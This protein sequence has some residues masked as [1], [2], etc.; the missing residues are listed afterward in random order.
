MTNG[1]H[2]RD[3]QQGGVRGRYLMPGSYI[4]VGKK[5]ITPQFWTDLSSPNGTCYS[6]ITFYQ[7]SQHSSCIPIHQRQNSDPSPSAAKVMLTP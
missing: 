5:I 7:A 1:A 6:N 2:R 4:A 3:E